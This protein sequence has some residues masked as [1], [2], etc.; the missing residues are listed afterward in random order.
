[1]GL[2]FGTITWRGDTCGWK[3]RSH[4]EVLQEPSKKWTNDVGQ[5]LM[6]TRQTRTSSEQL[7]FFLA[8]SPSPSPI[9]AR[10]I[11]SWTGCGWESEVHHG[12]EQFRGDDSG[13]GSKDGCDNRRMADKEM[14]F[15]NDPR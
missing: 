8:S 1:M 15:V 10:N 14:A 12:L 11:K 6:R 4:F 5:V 13:A 7:P 9:N 2:F 3:G